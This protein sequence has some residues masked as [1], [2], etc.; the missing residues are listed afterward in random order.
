[1][2][3]MRVGLRAIPL[4]PDDSDYEPGPDID[5]LGSPEEEPVPDALPDPVPVGK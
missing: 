4:G 1:M 5:A 2:D 3:D